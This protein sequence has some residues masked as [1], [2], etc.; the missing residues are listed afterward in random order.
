MFGEKCSLCGG[1]L[2]NNK[3]CTLC[4]L[5]NS[6]SEK[7][8]RI[9]KSDCDGQPLTHVHEAKPVKRVYP[10]GKTGQVKTKRIDSVRKSR[11]KKGRSWKWIATFITLLITVV[12]SLYEPV[13]DTIENIFDGNYDLLDNLTNSTDPTG[14]L[15]GDPYENVE[16]EL[17]AEGAQAEYE[18]TSGSY[19]V[20][21]HI[22]A[23]NYKA[24]TA[25]EF[26]VVRVTD[27]E[28]SIYLYEY[29]GS[30]DKNYLD[31]L[32]LYP[33]A[34]VEI[35]SET[36]VILRTNNGQE[37]TSL[38][39]PLVEKCTVTSAVKTAGEGFEAGVYDLEV[40]E[41]SGAVTVKIYDDNGQEYSE[42]GMYLGEYYSDGMQYKNLVL[43]PGAEISCESGMEVEM[44]PSPN[45]E[46]TDYM[47]FYKR[48]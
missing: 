11:Q 37:V 26:D 25:Y 29:E 7:Y 21:V 13:T 41:G 12:T 32:R 35:S 16:E 45:I 19:V 33:G 22:P 39:N 18:L 8:Y 40:K 43:P 44:T 6:K 42:K 17:L 2:D 31:D 24:E 3:V 4:G 30:D 47:S 38:E 27:Y 14:Y 5:D 10:V 1:K 23:G 20:G 28:R 46:S 36:I 48:Y 15:R 34:I 9:N